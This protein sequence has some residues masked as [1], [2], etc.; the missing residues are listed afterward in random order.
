[1]VIASFLFFL[2]CFMGIGILSALKSKGNNHD[3]LLAGSNIKPW[4]AALSAIATSCSGYMFIGMIGYTYLYGI[5]SMWIMLGFIV[6]DFVSSGFAFRRIR[7]AT[8]E[9]KVM[10][11]GGVISRWQ[12]GTDFTK[13][14]KLVG[15][16]TLIFL[17]T[18]AAAQ[19][20]A[21]S[22]AL[23]ILFGW[24]YKIGAILGAIMVFLY[25]TAGGIR[26]S[27]WTDAAQS[28]VMIISMT[29]LC[30]T[31]IYVLGGL[32]ATW[33]QMKMIGP[34]FVSLMPK[35]T[36]LAGPAG[37]ILFIA[38]WFIAG[39]GVIGQPHIMVRFMMVDDP[40]NMN[41]VRLYYYL[42][43]SAF[44][45]ITIMVGLL[46]RLLLPE[47]GSFDSELALPLLANQLLPSILI[48]VVL[49]GL[50]AATM[51]TADSQ[52]LSCCAAITRDLFPNKKEKII[53]TKL[54]TLGV[55]ATALTI[56]LFGTQSV[57][58]LICMSW[59]TLGCCFGPLIVLYCM[60]KRVTE[61]V[62]I[63][64]VIF[65][66][67]TALSFRYFGLHNHIN[68]IAPGVAMGFVVY[69][70]GTM[71]ENTTIPLRKLLIWITN[72]FK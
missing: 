11:F 10:S 30:F 25:C 67:I 4:L 31:S 64:M 58:D 33:V 54:T 46:T 22:K 27:I 24:D 2:L 59:S 32:E 35:H 52:I 29:I 62:A 21:G 14:R 65:A 1:M 20:A 3:Y 40:K 17:G 70:V 6:G 16:I 49:A 51:S 37:W 44:S 69:S 43:Y 9:R 66:F 39:F 5:S 48:G 68:E 41:K 42:W 45:A 60:K 8:E 12:K 63:F 28:F 38:G 18:Y 47:V 13:L 72:N 50:F 34:N 7:E 36:A 53:V 55:T 56:A 15:V 19:F 61:R 57:Y 26:A 23:H 71:M